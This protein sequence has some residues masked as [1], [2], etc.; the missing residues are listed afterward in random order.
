MDLKPFT[1]AFVRV[2][3]GLLIVL[4]GIDKIVDV[5]HAV[6]VSDSF[7]LGLFS[8]PLVL[9]AFG[10]LQTA[11][12]AA[13]VVGWRGRWVYPA[14]IVINGVSLLAVW[15]SIIDPWGW[16]LEGTNVFFFP[17]LL[18]FAASLLVLAW[19]DRDV[20]SLDGARNGPA[21]APPGRTPTRA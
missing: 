1:L 3:V 11:L 8:A 9:Q 17:S 19:R 14:V 7:Y 13:M 12:G 21:I 6:A 20:Y 10:V 15:R 18:I 5:D 2:S 4:W 16:F